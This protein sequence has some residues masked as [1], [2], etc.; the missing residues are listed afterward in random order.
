[1][2]YGSPIMDNVI[3]A[4]S[5][6][7]RYGM[8][9]TTEKYTA[10]DGETQTGFRCSPP[11]EFVRYPLSPPSQ[12][13][14]ISSPRGFMCY[15]EYMYPIIPMIPPSYYDDNRYRRWRR[16]RSRSRSPKN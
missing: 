14:C 10:V 7:N 9:V 6:C 4:M 11:R 13:R 3:D 1:M 15:P 16:S 8:D 5:Y 2:V 12:M